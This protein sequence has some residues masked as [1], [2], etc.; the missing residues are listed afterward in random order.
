MWDGGLTWLLS[1]K[2]LIDIYKQKNVQKTV[3]DKTR[4]HTSTYLN[5]LWDHRSISIDSDLGALQ[6]YFWV[7]MVTAAS[8]FFA[9][10][11]L[12]DKRCCW[13]FERPSFCRKSH[14]LGPL[15]LCFLS[16]PCPAGE[17][18]AVLVLVSDL[19]TWRWT[20]CQ[21][22]IPAAIQ[23]KAWFGRLY[24][25]FESNRLCG[26]GGMCTFFLMTSLWDDVWQ[27][28]HCATNFWIC[29]SWSVRQK[30]SDK[31]RLW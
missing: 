12:R 24:L 13:R 11:Q 9:W 30:L 5:S 4:P 28:F 20:V 29:F 1:L 25:S 2:T 21:R 27:T 3:F 10:M 8:P 15:K 19:L 7:V 31:V 17:L 18:F 6:P 26:F 14:R 23:T 16:S 22:S